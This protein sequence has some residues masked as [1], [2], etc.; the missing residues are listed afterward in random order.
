MTTTSGYSCRLGERSDHYG[1]D[2]TQ[3]ARLLG[4]L[5]AQKRTGSEAH[6]AA[7]DGSNET[8]HDDERQT[9]YGDRL[10]ALMG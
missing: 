7:A 5:E 8:V 9:E 1:P 2:Q 6:A 10:E 4:Y 3:N